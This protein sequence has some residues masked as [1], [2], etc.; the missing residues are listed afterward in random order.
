MCADA[1][2]GKTSESTLGAVSW[3][4]FDTSSMFLW[5]FLALSQ[6][7]YPLRSPWLMLHSIQVSQSFRLHYFLSISDKKNYS[8]T[9]GKLLHIQNSEWAYLVDFWADLAETWILGKCVEC[10]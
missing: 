2:E 10:G 6:R 9:S 4:F 7:L 1:R 3:L 5:A 8:A